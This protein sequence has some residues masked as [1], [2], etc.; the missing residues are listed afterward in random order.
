[1]ATLTDEW[2]LAAARIS[3]MI[4]EVQKAQDWTTTRARDRLKELKKLAAI[5]DYVGI[6]GSEPEMIS[7]RDRLVITPINYPKAKYREPFLV[8]RGREVAVYDWNGELVYKGE[9]LP[10]HDANYIKWCAGF[11][12]RLLG[13]KPPTH[14]P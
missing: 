9:L 6:L 11:F 12:V 8:E 5:K 14:G 1:M 4:W 13:V 2:H 7:L 10:E 3:P